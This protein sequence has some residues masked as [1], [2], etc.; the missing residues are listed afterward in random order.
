MQ[1]KVNGAPMFGRD[2]FFPSLPSLQYLTRARGLL[3]GGFRNVH[4][5]V[6]VWDLIRYCLAIRR[7]RDGRGGRCLPTLGQNA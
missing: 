4:T 7:T 1:A 3:F 5:S 2:S 6:Y